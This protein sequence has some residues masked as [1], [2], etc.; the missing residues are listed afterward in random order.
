MLDVPAEEFA[1]AYIVDFK[2]VSTQGLESSP[3]ADA[4]A[5]LRANEARS[6]EVEARRHHSRL[7][8]RHQG[9]VL[10]GSVLDSGCGKP[11]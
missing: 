7:L 11:C 4:F 5:G 8:L 2:T 3:V 10:T 6:A 9:R 1:V